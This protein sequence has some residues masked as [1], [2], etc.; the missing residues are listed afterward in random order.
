MSRKSINCVVMFAD[1][2][3]STAM[4]ENMG[5]EAARSRISKALNTMISICRRYKGKLVKTLG[6]E[7][8]VYFLDADLAVMAAKNI[9]ETMEDDRSA[10]TVGISIKIGMQYGDAILDDGD[11]FGDTVNVAARVSELAQARQIL[12]P[13]ELAAKII[14]QELSDNTRLFDRLQVKGRNEQLDLYIYSWEEDG[15]ITNMATVGNFTNPAK[16]NQV[17]AIA[18]DY[19]GQKIEINLDIR[20]FTLGRARDCDI[21]VNGH[22]TSRIHAL[23][24]IRRGKFV[25]VD[26]STN[27]SFIQLE[28][29]QEV[30]LRREELA[31]F[32]VGQISLGESN[33]AKGAQI[34][35]YVC[36]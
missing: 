13:G 29:G 36:L 4:Y 32:G 23:I 18:L 3:G 17:N 22:L 9:Q 33:N 5:D 7:I 2:V 30:F 31:M 19:A 16:N 21:S 1:V 28:N 14:N 10:E 27:G 15:E 26:Q 20:S 35:K 24:V 34:I 11:I 12:Y 8:M 25:F 6:D